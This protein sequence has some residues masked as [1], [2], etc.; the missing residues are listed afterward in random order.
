MERPEFPL[1][2]NKHACEPIEDFINEV[3]QFD[4]STIMPIPEN[5]YYQELLL[6]PIPLENRIAHLIPHVE[7]TAVKHVAHSIATKLGVD[8]KWVI[9]TAL[10]LG[11]ETQ[12]E[13]KING[14]TR[15]VYPPLTL[16]LLEEELG[17]LRAYESLNE[18]VS[19][20][21]IGQFLARHPDWVRYMAA[22]LEVYHTPKM[23]LE[24][25]IRGYGY[26]KQLTL[27]LRHLILLTPHAADR[28]TLDTLAGITGREKNWI[29]RK[30]KERGVEHD[31]R[32]SLLSGT[33]VR[34]FPPESL[35]IINEITENEPA[36]AGN[37]LTVGTMARLIGKDYEWVQVRV[38]KKYLD[39]AAFRLDDDHKK[40]IHYPPEVFGLL[41]QE[42]KEA[43]SYEIAGTNDL[44]LSALARQLGRDQKW[45]VARL[46]YTTVDPIVK[47]NPVNNRLL[48]YYSE[49]V[50]GIL[51]ELPQDILKRNSKQTN[52]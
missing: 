52:R 20:F 37:W 18:Q 26:P 30:L 15:E 36:P 49:D 50:V 1:E 39:Q 9:N 44:A 7:L 10:S 5:T 23:K 41:Q 16:E 48:S 11:I 3:E 43:E 4:V 38:Q 13:I 25:G 24:S 32:R 12:A 22:E 19:A 28:L 8:K 29:E 46:P 27:Q 40:K 6:Q 47:R 17:W 33:I 51:L 14:G 21:T 2:S 35:D 34:H 42:A 45:V 31:Q